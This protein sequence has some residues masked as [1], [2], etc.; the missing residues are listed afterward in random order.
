MD[1]LTKLLVFVWAVAALAAEIWIWRG[2]WRA[3]PELALAA[4][5]AAAVLTAFDRRAVALALVFAYVFPLLIYLYMGTRFAQYGAV[6]MAPL[7]G[8]MLP[9]AL[10]TGW[11]IPGPWRAPIICG[12]LTIVAGPTIVVAREVDFTPALITVTTVANTAGGGWPSFVVSWILH[13]ALV[14]LIGILWFDWLFQSTPRDFDM[15]VATPLMVS[16]A[17][18]TALAAYQLFADVTFLNPTVY[19]AIAR[20]SGTVLD[21]NICG[22]L[23]ALWIGGVLLWADQPGAWRRYVAAAGVAAGWLAVW[24]SGSRTAFAAAAIVTAF[25]LFAL[26]SRQRRVSGRRAA[27]LAGGAAVVLVLLLALLAALD[28]G[29]VGPAA[30][31]WATLPEPSLQS[32][33]DVAAEMWNRNGYGSAATAMIREFP[34]FGVGIG[35]FQMLLPEFIA[36]PGGIPPDNAQNWYRHQLAELGIVGSAGWLV[37]VMLFVPFLLA[38]RPAAPA[39]SWIARGAL[40][41]LGAISLVGMPGQ[42]VSVSVTFATLAFWYC[43]IVGAPAPA[44]VSLRAWGAIAAVLVLFAAGTAFAATHGLRVPVRAQRGG[45]TYSYGFYPPGTFGNDGEGRW[46]GR[47]AVAVID[48]PTRWLALTLSVD[49]QGIGNGASSDRAPGHAPIRPVDIKVW[50]DGQLVVERRLVDTSPV[51]EYVSIPG[52]APRVML[53]T[54]VSRVL[55]PRELGVPDDREL[56][57]LVSWRF[58]DAAPTRADLSSTRAAPASSA[59]APAR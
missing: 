45:W 32:V 26:Y 22:T 58:V 1:R 34:W 25:S 24:A 57:M 16:V 39:R 48:A 49:H 36:Q 12:A 52:A 29:V 20:A 14:L 30:R 47:R 11:H 27:A 3:L 8:A 28:L 35:S 43:A 2:A 6:W 13:T 42:D 17:A 19:G 51:T 46:T 15:G 31:L 41:A 56:G 5:V 37:C 18:M 33:R 38:R 55:R 44:P 54:W 59:A 4:F 53:E 23:A 7:L 9:A 21:A 50:R 10:T 40:V